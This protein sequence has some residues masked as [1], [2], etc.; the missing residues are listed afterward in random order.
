MSP[1][2]LETMAFISIHMHRG[3]ESVWACEIA[4]KPSAM[5]LHQKRERMKVSEESPSS[6]P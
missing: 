6:E 4:G 3:V 5:F 2:T 1:G